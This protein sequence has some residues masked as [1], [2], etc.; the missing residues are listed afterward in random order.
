MDKPSYNFQ[1]SQNH[2]IYYFESIGKETIKEV[3]IYQ[4]IEGSPNVVELAFGNLNEDFTIDVMAINDNKNM[5]LVISTVIFTVIDYL[6]YFPNKKVF[7]RGSTPSRTRLYR[8][9]IS[10][11]LHIF[12]PS[13][14]V[15]GFISDTEIE[16]FDKKSY[17]TA[18]LI[19]KKYEKVNK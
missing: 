15:F 1:V 2:Q 17:Y 14:Q 6:N 10:K 4:P 9:A 19:Q 13:F 18:Y 11:S 5:P 12:E 3:V 8:A 16:I 7:F